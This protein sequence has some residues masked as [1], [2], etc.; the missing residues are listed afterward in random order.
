MTQRRQ[1]RVIKGPLWARQVEPPGFAKAK[2]KGSAAKGKTYE[3]KV[4]KYVNKWIE[5]EGRTELA[6]IYQPWIQF[7]DANGWGLASPDIVL[8][9]PDRVVVLEAKLSQTAAAEH[10]LV[11]TYFPLLSLLFAKPV[12]GIQVCKNMYEHPKHSVR[13]LVGHLDGDLDEILPV[14]TWHLTL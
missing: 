2:L 4:W 9:A 5:Q 8:V 13:N 3:R 7:E 1:S 12:F 14:M 6:P 11:K 10:Q